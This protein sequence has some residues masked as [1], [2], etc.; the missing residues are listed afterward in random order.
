MILQSVKGILGLDKIK[1]NHGQTARMI[2]LEP[3]DLFEKLEFDKILE[4]VEQEC[5]GD[6]GKLAVLEI[7]PET[8]KASILHKLKQVAEYQITL[9]SDPFPMT[10]YEDLAKDLKM[11]EIIDYVLPIEGMQRINVI[12]RATQAVFKYFVEERQAIYPTL[13]NLIRP[14]TFDAALIQEIEKVI[15]EEGKIREDASPRLQKIRRSKGAK[16]KELDKQFR[17]IIS[18]YRSQGWLSDTVESFRNGRRVLSVPAEHKRKVRGIIHDESTTGRTAF[19]EPE[20]IISINNDIFEL[21]VEERREIYNILKELSAILRPYAPAMRDYQELMIKIDVIQA[22]AR[23]SYRIGGELPQLKSKPFIKIKTGYHPLLLLKNKQQNKKTI[24]FDLV[25]YK[26]N[27]VLMLSGPNAGG[28]SI[29]LKSVGLLQLMLQSGLLIPVEPIS[30][31]GIFDGIFADIGD[32]QSIEDDLSTY[33]SRLRNA[34]IFLDKATSKSLILIDEFGSGTDPVIGGAIAESILKS[35]NDRKVHGVITTHYSNLKLYAHKTPGVVNGSMTFDKDTLSPT[36]QLKVGRPGSSY[37]YEIAQKV[38]LHK[39]VLEYAKKKTGKKEK[40]VDQLLVD[41]QK[42]KQELEEHL[43]AS[44]E[45]EKTLN[46]LIKNY[47]HLYKDMEYRRKKRRLEIKEEALQQTSKENKELEKLVREIKEDSRLSEKRRLEKAKQ[48]AA[49]VKQE[50]EKIAEQVVQIK[51]EIYYQPSAKAN[52]ALKVGDYVKLRTGGTTGI[53]EGIHK[54]KAVIQMGIMH[55]TV[56]LRDIEGANEPLEVNKTKKVQ[57][58]TVGADAK[59]ESE[60][61]L[62]GMRYEEALKV[63]QDF[64]DQAL[65][66]SATSIRI[67]HGKGTG[68]L[69]KAV[70]KKLREYRD[71]KA[72]HHPPRESGGDGVTIVDMV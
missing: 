30:E 64:V 1:A 3:G 61:D 23:L 28:K 14:L 44:Q 41:L 20:E 65:I 22:K 11:L 13:Y 70:H 37:A 21:E 59:F 9:S 49:K 16:V 5:F 63:L 12:L 58:D 8:D 15:D 26:E 67:I 50:K 39:E 35:L 62:R 19:I 40:A 53:I 51:E 43:K 18:K 42:E 6:L 29:T 55:L 57:L 47:E 72:Y 36:Y 10:A 68:V 52:R 56:P 38:G 33:S 45:K 24:P 60:I 27:R 31:M 17:V 34:R 71:I 25:F 7:Y 69:R 32:Q 4:L 46:R 48:L 2:Q 54:G 66:S